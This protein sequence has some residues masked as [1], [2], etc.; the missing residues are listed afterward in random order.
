M[1]RFLIGLPGAWQ[2]VPTLSFAGSSQH[3]GLCSSACNTNMPSNK[4]VRTFTRPSYVAS[5]SVL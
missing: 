3:A 4:M 2:K 5:A 1:A